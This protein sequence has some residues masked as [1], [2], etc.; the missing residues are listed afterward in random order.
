MERTLFC[1]AIAIKFSTFSVL[2]LKG[3]MQSNTGMSTKMTSRVMFCLKDTKILYTGST[4]IKRKHKKINKEKISWNFSISSIVKRGRQICVT[5]KLHLVTYK[6]SEYTRFCGEWW[7]DWL[8]YWQFE[9]LGLA[10]WREEIDTSSE[11]CL[12][13]IKI[14]QSDLIILVQ[15]NR[16]C[17]STLWRCHSCYESFL[18]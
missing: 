11:W 18:L 12:F 6:I 4:E 3:D 7:K 8:G 2:F 15:R 17:E 1:S 9:G 14:A 5:L 16:E 13:V 10:G